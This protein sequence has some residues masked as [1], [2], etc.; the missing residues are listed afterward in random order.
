MKF[1]MSRENHRLVCDGIIKIDGDFWFSSFSANGLMRVDGKTSQGQY[2]C[3]FPG[4]DMNHVRLYTVGTVY[5]TTIVLTPSE[6]NAIA[7]FDIHCKKLKM[8]PFPHRPIVDR[9]TWAGQGA[10]FR[11][12][13]LY[14]NYAYF[15][16]M[17]YRGILCLNLDTEELILIDEWI[18]VCDALTPKGSSDIYMGYSSVEGEIAYIPFSCADAILILNM[19]TREVHVERV[20]SGVQGFYGMMKIGDDIWLSPTQFDDIVCWNIKTKSILRLH[21]DYDEKHE[22][23]PMYQPLQLKNSLYFFPIFSN[24][25]FRVDLQSKQLSV[26]HHFDFIFEAKRVK[27]SIGWDYVQA[28][29]VIDGKLVFITAKDCIWHI[30]D[31]E[32][33]S[34]ESIAVTPDDNC[35]KKLLEEEFKSGG[36]I[37]IESG[38]L[39][40]RDYIGYVGQ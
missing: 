39:G 21:P 18:P 13:L 7:L 25:M 20:D 24:R 4:Q 27:R 15:I 1:N 2:V 9:K 30:Y 12:V 23:S 35:Y 38:E 16:P 19:R 34:H 11:E 28:P 29:S 26:D 14:Q 32:D 3:S 40:L 8:I 22:I 17:N 33:N 36:D 37:F 10:R 6:A 31:P 5:G